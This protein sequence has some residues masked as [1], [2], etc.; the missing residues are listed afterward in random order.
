MGGFANVF[1]GMFGVSR[2]QTNN[3]AEDLKKSDDFLDKAELIELSAANDGSEVID[4]SYTG[5]VSNIN[6]LTRSFTS[7]QEIVAGYRNMSLQPEVDSAVDD[8]INAAITSDSDEDPISLDLTKLELPDAKAEIIN[9]EFETILDLM[10]FNATAY[11]KFR[12]FYIDGRLANHIAVDPTNKKDG[13]KHIV[14]LDPRSVKKV[15]ELKKKPVPG[16]GVEL[17]SSVRKFYI[18]DPMLAVD[19]NSA[20]STSFS[21]S[22]LQKKKLEIDEEAIVL[23]HCGL[24]SPDGQILSHLEKAKKVLNNMNL[25]EDSM[26]IYRLVRAPARRAFY[27]DTGSLPKKAAEEFVFGLMEKYKSKMSYDAKSGKIA[28]NQHQMTIMEDFWLPRREG[29]K[30]TE[31]STIE[32]AANMGDIDDVLLLQKKLYRSLNVPLSRL[33]SDA[34]IVLGGR[35]AEISRDEWKFGKFI[36]R[37]RR[38]FSMMFLDILGLQLVMKEICTKEEWA[39]WKKKIEFKYSSDTY[40]KEQQEL[41]ILTNQV[42][43][44]TQM[45]S[46][47]G[48]YWS[49]QTIERV[50]LRRTEEEIKKEK[51][52]MDKEE[53][54]NPKPVEEE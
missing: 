27:V 43:I 16:S 28:G 13:I 25:I 46:L 10:D 40:T 50:V 14:L 38:R 8:I 35:S 6:V 24:I 15:T 31:V 18:Y 52:Q 26:V 39:E 32:G 11:E 54:E 33:E 5:A 4:V 48:R 7:Q 23:T 29:G 17:V 49:K 3:T 12:Q 44:V 30:G 36:Q 2:R 42:N 21:A 22:F 34:N 1:A 9:A 19:N 53:K 51:A 45:D 20:N 41:D 37:L 47:V